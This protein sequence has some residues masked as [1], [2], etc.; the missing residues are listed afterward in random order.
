M[1]RNIP[2]DEQETTINL[3]PRKLNDR[4]EIYSSDP[5]MINRLTK[6]MAKH[7]GEV[8]VLHEDQYGMT[9][10]VS[11]KWIKISAPRKVNMTDDQRRASAERLRAAREVKQNDSV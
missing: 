9:V 2:L 4:A 8:S 7:P 6:L 3:F 10:S 5:L 1:K 11:Q